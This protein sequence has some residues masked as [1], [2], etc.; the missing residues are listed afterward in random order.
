MFQLAVPSRDVVPS[1]VEYRRE[2]QACVERINRRFETP[3]WTPV[4]YVL[5]S[6][7]PAQLRELYCDADVMLVTSLRDGMNLVAKEFV[8]CRTDDDG[9]LVLSEFAGASEEL[10]GALIVNPYSVEQLADAIHTALTMGRE[11]RRERMLTLRAQVATR[12]VHQWVDAFMADL[13][14]AP[15]PSE[16]ATDLPLT[17][18]LRSAIDG[19][20]RLSLAFVYEEALIDAPEGMPVHPDPELIEALGRMATRS[21]VGVHIISAVDHAVLGRWFEFV[22]VT[23]WAEHGLWHR[24]RDERRWRRTQTLDPD[25]TADLREFL[26]QFTGRTPGSFVEER[27]TGFAW[28]FGRMNRGTGDA[29]ARELFA[30]LQEAGDAMGFTVTLKPSSIEVRPG[31]LSRERTVEKILAADASAGRLVVFERPGKEN[32]LRHV[33]RPSDVLVAIGAA[34]ASADHVLSSTRTVRDVLE[35]AFEAVGHDLEHAR[36]DDRSFFSPAVSAL[37]GVADQPVS[38]AALMNRAGP[39][40]RPDDR[41]SRRPSLRCLPDTCQLVSVFSSLKAPS[42]LGQG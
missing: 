10:R 20:Q 15:L 2:V 7:A 29:R 6:L 41:V 27:S 24:R 35:S 8:S 14:S 33:L 22:P 25:W 40:A 1:Y 42:R 11:D 37:P 3:D 31:E 38:L 21:D 5:G 19:A 17:K 32:G 36:L 9:V 16:S 12:T 4:R 13:A 30:V 39:C 34:A 28:H 23:L 26:E 18:I